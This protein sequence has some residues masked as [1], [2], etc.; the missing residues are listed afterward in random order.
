M[1]IQYMYV[2]VETSAIKNI[3]HAGVLFNPCMYVP[4][5]PIN[6]LLVVSCIQCKY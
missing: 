1:F 3:L 2:V 4:F 5:E 6:P